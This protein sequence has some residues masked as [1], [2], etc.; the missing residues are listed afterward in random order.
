MSLGAHVDV[1][2]VLRKAAASFTRI[3]FDVTYI[4][5]LLITG[6]KIRAGGRVVCFAFSNGP[7]TGKNRMLLYPAFG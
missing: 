4:W 5:V 2:A 1:V 6:R 3:P 7:E